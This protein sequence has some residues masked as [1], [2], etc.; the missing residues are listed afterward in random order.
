MRTPHGDHVILPVVWSRFRER[1]VAA[2]EED[3]K[4]FTAFRILGAITDVARCEDM[5]ALGSGRIVNIKPGR[6]GGFTVARRIHDVCAR[7]M[8]LRVR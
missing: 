3:S 2:F 8:A 5:I 6:V 1:F 4:R 7:A